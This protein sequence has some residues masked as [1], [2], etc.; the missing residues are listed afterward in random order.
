M[1]AANR[2]VLPGHATARRPAVHRRR[3]SRRSANALTTIGAIVTV[4]V[5]W[6][7]AGRL[8]EDRRTLAAPSA[9]WRELADHPGLYWRNLRHTGWNALR[10]FFWGNVVALA[11]ATIAVAVRPLRKVIYDVALTTTCLPLV[12]MAPILRVVLGRGEATPIALGALAVVFTSLNAALLGFDS[13]DRSS[14]D[15]VAAGGRGRLFALWYVHARSAVPSLFAGF[16]I[17]APAAFLGVL[18][19]EFTGSSSG[20]GLLTIRALASLDPARVWTVALLATVVSGSLYWAIGVIGRRLTPWAATNTIAAPLVGGRRRII[21]SV[22]RLLTSVVVVIVGWVALLRWSGLNSYF[23]KGPADVWRYLVGDAGA[24]ARRAPILDALGETC[25]TAAMGF[26]VGLIGAVL[27]AGVLAAFPRLA[28]LVMPFAIALRVV[29]IVSTTPLIILLF[30][31]GAV[32]SVVIVAVMS[33]F[34]TLVSCLVAMQ[35]SPGQVVDVL[36]SYGAGQ[37]SL[38]ARVRLPNSMP[39]LASS[40]RI[41]V[42][43]SLLGAT[44]AEWLATGRGIGNAMVVAASTARYDTLWS[45][46]VLLTLTA[47]LAHAVVAAV[48]SAVLA[49]YAPGRRS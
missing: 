38:F 13:A 24:A 3:L 27:L 42:P 44:V 43:A 20:L 41:A 18:V 32:G 10:A 30:G 31:R 26:V 48:E 12:A 15:V 7:A 2:A 21:G 40:A 29:P 47:L 16:Q 36:H 33:F 23:A 1:T 22:G 5:L 9:I 49:R 14:L 17:A 37:A 19:G 6:E 11:L 25:R 35:R 4:L 34:P 8:L 46:V 45:C 39:A 28:S